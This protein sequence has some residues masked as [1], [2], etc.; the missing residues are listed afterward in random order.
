[1]IRKCR[2]CGTEVSF[3]ENSTAAICPKCGE[4]IFAP[5]TQS[6]N[7]KPKIPLHEPETGR[8]ISAAED[9]PDAEEPMPLFPLPF[10]TADVPGASNTPKDT[11]YDPELTNRLT[12]W[13]QMKKMRKKLLA[14]G[15]GFAVLLGVFA[16]VFCT[17]IMPVLRYRQALDS[18]ENGD[19][20][21]AFAR[22]D[23]LKGF[24]DSDEKR[25]E[26][27]ICLLADAQT[28]DT[29]LFGQFDQDNDPS[30]G[31]E[32]V[33]WRVL[34]REQ[35]RMLLITQSV[36]DAAAYNVVNQDTTWEKCS[37]RKWLN[38]T[39]LATA[40]SASEQRL[41]QPTE[42]SAQANP[43]YPTNPGNK[44]TDRVFL[45]GIEDVQLYFANS[46]SDRISAATEYALQRKIVVNETTGGSPWW[47]RTP[48]Y[49]G[50]FAA[51]VRSD[52]RGN[53]D[54]TNVATAGCGVRPAVWLDLGN[55]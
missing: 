23:E 21:T 42:L 45:L 8:P 9:M 53:A 13:E 20:P 31:K 39:F 55:R 40:F 10:K 33:Q 15:L 2:F 32:N 46:D 22:F 44:T 17:R 16:A 1:M 28:G 6:E 36:L 51:F 30:N 4:L 19:Y 41:L 7:P 50:S 26:A 5:K 14:A 27:G 34:A 37:L 12:A 35:D 18:L 25:I 52:G 47:V 24:R 29:V 43:C 48:G 11:P 3:G 38:S 54:G 49:E